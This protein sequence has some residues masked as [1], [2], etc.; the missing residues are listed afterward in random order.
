MHCLVNKINHLH[1]EAR[2]KKSVGCGFLSVKC[3]KC[4]SSLE[5]R[6]ATT[7]VPFQSELE[8][9]ASSGQ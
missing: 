6:V 2:D 3:G 1:L 5:F 7:G 4:S 8:E 9:S